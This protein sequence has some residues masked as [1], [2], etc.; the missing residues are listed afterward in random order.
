LVDFL[1]FFFFFFFVVVVSST[2]GEV[3]WS[4]DDVWGTQV[5]D[6]SVEGTCPTIWSMSVETC[7]VATAAMDDSKT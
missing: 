5:I 4:G 7:S 3:S 6:E 2:S 1:D